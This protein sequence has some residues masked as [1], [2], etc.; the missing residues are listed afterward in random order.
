MISPSPLRL[1][2]IRACFLLLVVGLFIQIVPDLFG[3]A[4]SMSAMAGVVVAMLSALAILSI[5]GLFS[6][7]KMLPL[8]LFEMLWKLLWTC[9]VAL[10]H[11]LAGTITEELGELMFAVAFVIPFV[12]IFPW[13]F[14]STE[15]RNSFVPWR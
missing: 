3:P 8:M 13:R 6:P 7:I 4:A 10:P 14:W 2:L 9:S 11:F 15:I 1:N 5:V 12:F